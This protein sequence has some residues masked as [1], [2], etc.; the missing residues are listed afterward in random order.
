MQYRSIRVVQPEQFG[1]ATA[2]T[3]DHSALLPS[4]QAPALNR[5]CGWAI[6]A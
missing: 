5:P 6:S 2:Q 3:P 4:I 1:S